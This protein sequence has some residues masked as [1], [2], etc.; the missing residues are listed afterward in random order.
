M[1]HG[2]IPLGSGPR[3]LC[4]STE[5]EKEDPRVSSLH[6]VLHTVTN[7]LLDGVLLCNMESG[8]VP[9]DINSITFS[10]VNPSHWLSWGA[11]G[12]Q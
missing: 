6:C 3:G 12:N 5:A 8:Y 2:E 4:P 10:N 11:P 1:V 7:L 9:V